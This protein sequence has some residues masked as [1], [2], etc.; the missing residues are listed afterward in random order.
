[1]TPDLKDIPIVKDFLKVFPKELN[2]LL[3]QC[4]VE[5]VIELE[6]NMA[7]IS[8]ASYR[9]ALSELKELKV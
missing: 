1:M 9:I 5:F 2:N 4:K 7:S 3:P 8:K 6:A